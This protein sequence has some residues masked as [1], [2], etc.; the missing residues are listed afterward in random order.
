VR[1]PTCRALRARGENAS[2][3]W[4]LSIPGRGN[5]FLADKGLRG[6]IDRIG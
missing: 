6:M 1:G 2:E 4:N 5:G 3:K